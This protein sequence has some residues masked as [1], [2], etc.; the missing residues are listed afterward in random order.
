[1]P[2]VVETQDENE[3]CQAAYDTWIAEIRRQ[4]QTGTEPASFRAGWLA[5]LAYT[6][7]QTNE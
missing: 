4:W 2:E 3:R 7:S 5:G 1:M 6:K